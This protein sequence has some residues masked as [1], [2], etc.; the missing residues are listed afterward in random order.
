M[1]DLVLYSPQKLRPA[2]MDI[3]KAIAEDYPEIGQVAEWKRGINPFL[4]TLCFNAIPEETPLKYIKTMSQK[5]VLAKASAVTEI[6]AALDQL[7]RP[8]ELRPFHYE[9]W[10][11]SRFHDVPDMGDVVVV[12]I[13]T[14]GDIKAWL[15]E[16]MWLLSCALYDGKKLIVLSEEWLANEENKQILIAFLT[17]R[18]RKL[19]A[20][21]MKF[22][23]RSLSALLGVTI[24]GHMDTQL[25]HHSI[26]PGSGEHGLKPLATKYLGAPDWD[27]SSKQYVKGNYKLMPTD[28]YY[29]KHL[30][31]KYVEKFGAV[32]VGFEAIPREI[33]YEYNAWDVYWTWHLMEYLLEFAD[34][35][36]TRVAL[37]E[38][39]M[40]NFFQDI[41]GYGMAV[42]V[43]HLDALAVEFGAERDKHMGKLA[44]MVSPDFNPNSPKQVKEVFASAGI[45][46]TSTA[47]GVLTDLKQTE[48]HPQVEAFIDTLLDVRGTTKMIG[49]YNEGIR[50]RMHGGRVYPTYK[51]HG[52][53]TGRMSSADPNI[54]NIP[55]DKR[56]RKLFTVRDTE[57]Y[58]FLEVDYSQAEL[59]TMAI[60][61]DDPYLISLF[62]PGMPD[63]FDSLLPVTFPHHNIDEWNAQERKDNRAKLKSVIYGLS[64]G[65][66]APA[67][68]RELGIATREAAS[69]IENYF[70]AAPDFYHWRQDVEL[71]ALS[72]SGTL[73][74]VFGRRFQAEIITGRSKTNVVN[75]ALAFLPQSTASDI[76]VTAAMEIHKW[77]GPDYGA[78]IIGSI[79]DAILVE[80]PKT[81]TK[82]IAARMQDEMATAARLA[83][84]GAVPFDTDAEWGTSWGTTGKD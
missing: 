40:G 73:E 84:G 27:S 68:A 55:R 31:D 25:L 76:C 51:V 45:N 50:K 29:P 38:Y 2:V 37:H 70:K 77:I 1:A 71:Q 42:N 43:E 58:D 9:V 5:Q 49:T 46:L 32:K 52:T 30:Y 44:E 48:I 36:V 6:K 53:N 83:L 54:Q 28:Y 74:T 23:F 35:R 72:S 41:E 56:L 15:P 57:Q 61:S 21:N 16:E 65:R 22:D 69:I 63:F 62:Q 64:Y 47:E 66:K 67:I 24:Y 59:R 3:V 4:P 19:I 14:G 60:L 82:E 33:L 80:S 13:E 79:H 81:Y 75:S 39:R 7:F 18:Q 78:N 11:R 10:G 8:R 34:E 17:R 26:N 20:H 12:D